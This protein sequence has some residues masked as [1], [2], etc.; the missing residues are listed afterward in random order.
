MVGGAAMGAAALKWLRAVL[1]YM[2]GRKLVAKQTGIYSLV[3]VPTGHFY[4]GSTR[5]VDGRT[6]DWMNIL[7][8]TLKVCPDGVWRQGAE[9]SRDFF[10]FAWKPREWE[11]FIIE[12]LAEDVSD[13]VIEKR[14]RF[15]IVK[16][17][18]NPLCLNVS[19]NTPTS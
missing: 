5:D 9:L 12:P 3:H 14:E 15:H 2:W 16:A 18:S 13:E 19:S 6:A 11:V 4:I 1:A 17:K 8:R 10:K 7:A